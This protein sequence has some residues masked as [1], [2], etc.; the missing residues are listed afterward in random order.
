MPWCHHWSRT[1]E[2]YINNRSWSLDLRIVW[3]QKV[4]SKSTTLDFGHFV[5]W[6]F[7]NVRLE[8]STFLDYSHWTLFY[9][10]IISKFLFSF[11]VVIQSVLLVQSISTDNSVKW[12]NHFFVTNMFTLS[13]QISQNRLESIN[14]VSRPHV[15][16][17]FCHVSVIQSLYLLSLTHWGLN[18]KMATNLQTFFQMHFFKEPV[19]RLFYLYNGNLYAR[20]TVGYISIC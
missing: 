16:V 7:N 1:H 15:Q 20:K 3:S 12:F 8:K 17:H 4:E 18:N 10:K 13:S 14:H 5:L 19:S 6:L 11:Y 9:R 2:F